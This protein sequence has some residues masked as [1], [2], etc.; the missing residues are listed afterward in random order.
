MDEEES[1]VVANQNLR[2]DRVAHPA[3]GWFQPSDIGEFALVVNSDE[4]LAVGVRA[5]RSSSCGFFQ[6]T[7]FI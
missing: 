1:A 7:N 4:M 2:D 5:L 3:S 6:Y